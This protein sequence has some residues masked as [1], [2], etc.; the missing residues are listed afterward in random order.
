MS[1]TTALYGLAGE[2]LALT[3]TPTLASGSVATGYGLANLANSNPAVPCRPTT[4]PTIIAWDFGSAKLL[5]LIALINTK[6]V[7]TVKVLANTSNTWFAPALSITWPNLGVDEEGYPPSAWLDLSAYSG[8]TAYR[9]WAVLAEGDGISI[10]EVWF[11]TGIYRFEYGPLI[12]SPVMA[13]QRKNYSLDTDLGTQMVYD[14]GARI[15]PTT[16]VKLLMSGAV[17]VPQY[18]TLRRSA[19]EMLLPW[20]FAPNPDVIST[21][22][23]FLGSGIQL[24]RFATDNYALTPIENGHH[25]TSF[26]VRALGLGLKP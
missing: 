6:V 8:N 17:G 11:G 13:E 18:Q 23:F 25:S 15:S 12:N 14:L 10:G 22:P 20:V 1:K 9:Y 2:N 24:V 21:I 5:N 16:G 26:D 4:N 3:T 19:R 7:G